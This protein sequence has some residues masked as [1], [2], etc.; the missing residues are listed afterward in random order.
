[1]CGRK[2]PNVKK[3]A[4]LRSNALG[5]YV[6]SLPALHAIRH[7]YP[8][9]DIVLLA[10]QWH[11]A[12]L[13]E[14]PAPVDRVEIVPLMKGICSG[15]D[16][17]EDAPETVGRFFE[18]MRAE[19]FD[20]AVQLYGGGRYSNP[21]VKE[22]HARLTVGMKTPDACEL[23]RWIPYVYYQPEV[24]RLLEVASLIGAAPAGL[25]PGVA[26]TAKDIANA[27]SL[28]NT[29]DKPVVVIHPGATDTRRRWSP[30]KFA[31]VGDALADAGAKVVVTGNREEK[32][33]CGEVCGNMRSPGLS[34]AGLF[35]L[36]S[37]TGL[38]AASFLLVA[39]DTGPLHLA[40]AV[41]VPTVGI[42]WVGNMING[43]PI[44]VN[45]NRTHISFRT[46]CPVCSVDCINGK[47]EHRDSFVEDISVEAVIGS[48]LELFAQKRAAVLA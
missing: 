28:L 17:K 23:D 15:A 37:F 9:A 22:L 29:E 41:N 18:R 31:K 10:C 26:V 3:I 1:M 34:T 39:N 30:A 21:F 38:I 8:R 45:W 33:V 43:G 2:I 35:S 19:K 6:F 46:L 14:R 42:Y 40:R 7:A 20:I 4:V 5:D 11:A 32:E 16:E 24:L 13:K 47:C 27:Y 25:E 36:N 44:S 12:F 48:A